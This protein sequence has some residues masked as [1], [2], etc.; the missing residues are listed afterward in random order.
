MNNYLPSKEFLMGICILLFILSVAFIIAYITCKGNE[1]FLDKID[2][3]GARENPQ[4]DQPLAFRD[5][6][7]ASPCKPWVGC[8]YP[9]PNP[10]NIQTGEREPE[11]DVKTCEKA[12]RDCPAYANCVNG[13]CK[14]KADNY[15]GF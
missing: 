5:Q 12:W 10:V 8:L 14:P 7:M 4:I 11:P 13:Q 9:M 2:F 1:N 6:L 15:N 3:A